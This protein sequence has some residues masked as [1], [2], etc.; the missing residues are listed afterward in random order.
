MPG[1]AMGAA[2]GLQLVGG[3]LKGISA[4]NAADANASIDNANASMADQAGG[5]ARENGQQQA[6]MR[7]MQGSRLAGSQ[8]AGFSASGVAT[9]AGSVLSVLDDTALVSKE[10]QDVIQNNAARTA[11]GYD[12][13]ATNFRNKATLDQQEGESEELGGILGGVTSAAGTASQIKLG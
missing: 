13:Q 6:T 12:A 8:T 1:A 2:A 3:V 7:A 9:N 11:W 4:K 5:V 10:D